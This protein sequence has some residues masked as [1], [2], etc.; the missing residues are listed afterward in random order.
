MAV[1]FDET[2][3]VAH[4]RRGHRRDRFGGAGDVDDDARLDGTGPD[5][6]G[7]LVSG[8]YD[9]RATRRETELR[10]DVGQQRADYLGRR[11]HR[12]EHRWVQISC[13]TESFVEITAGEVVEHR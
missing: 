6:R 9:H 1:R 10:G 13:R 3:R 7:M 2:E 11:A 8:S 12:R 5:R 4:G